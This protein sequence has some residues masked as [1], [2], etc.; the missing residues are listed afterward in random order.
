MKLACMRTPIGLLWICPACGGRTAT[1]PLLRKT[2]PLPTVNT[3]W[4]TAK[5]ARPSQHRKCPACTRLMNEIPVPGTDGFVLLDVCMPCQ[6]VWF[7]PLEYDK[8][9]KLP[10]QNKSFPDSLPQ[11]AREKLA[12]AQLDIIRENAEDRFGDDGTPDVWWQYIPAAL[13][14]PVEDNDRIIHL[15]IVTWL[16]AALISAVSIFAFH[17]LKYIVTLFGMIPAESLRYGGLTLVTSFFLHGGAWHL[18]G[19]LY[20]FLIFGDN[21]EDILGGRKFILLLLLSTVCGDI[22]HILSDPNSSIPCIGAS[23]GISGVI[24]YYAFAFPKARIGLLFYWRYVRLSVFVWFA[25]WFGLQILGTHTQ[26]YGTSNVSS[27]AHLGGAA[28]GILFWII[29]RKE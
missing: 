26:L 17:D 13:G 28:T 1:L 3:L 22:L 18:A 21:V 11:V 19:N 9:Q 12:I 7:D 14:L 16:T 8:F 29:T 5:T 23:G 6:C 20:F 2:L 25:M 4:Q 27:L 15:P 10:E 24:A